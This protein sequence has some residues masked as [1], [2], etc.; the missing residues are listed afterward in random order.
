MPQPAPASEEMP[1]PPDGAPPVPEPAPEP[2]PAPVPAPAP[3][4]APEPAPPQEPVAKTFG[5][6]L[7]QQP[8][9]E[10]AERLLR[11]GAFIQQEAEKTSQTRRV[12][13]ASEYK[14][15]AA[16]AMTLNLDEVTYGEIET[17]D[18]RL[19]ADARTFE[20]A[21]TARQEAMKAAGVCDQ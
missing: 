2:A 6:P 7:C 5:C 20:Q 17:L 10:G 19:A 21:L 3:E 15:F 13:L 8:L 18:P 12:E 1:P 16:H 14:S 4:P 11:F 9:N